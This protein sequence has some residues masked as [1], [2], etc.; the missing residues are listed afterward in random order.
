MDPD[1]MSPSSQDDL[2]VLGIVI[3]SMM[4]IYFVK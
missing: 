4:L 3:A 2:L 1:L